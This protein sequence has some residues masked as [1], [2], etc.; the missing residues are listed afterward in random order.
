MITAMFR[1]T[2][3]VSSVRSV[4]C[5]EAGEGAADAVRGEGPPAV[6]EVA[7]VG[8]AGAVEEQRDHHAGDQAERDPGAPSCASRRS[9]SAAR[10]AP[11]TA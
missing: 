1:S 9:G 8:L 11:A 4:P 5:A 7:G 2:N 10:G 3:T 6:G